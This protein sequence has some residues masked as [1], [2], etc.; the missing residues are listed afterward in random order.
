MGLTKVFHNE[1]EEETTNEQN[2][3]PL[4]VDIA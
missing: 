2:N 4:V 3:H 1:Q